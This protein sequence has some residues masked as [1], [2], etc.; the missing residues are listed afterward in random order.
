MS[1]TTPTAKKEEPGSETI[2]TPT[3]QSGEKTASRAARIAQEASAHADEHLHAK[4]HTPSPPGSTRTRPA[5]THARPPRPHVPHAPHPLYAPHTPHAPHAPHA[6]RTRPARTLRMHGCTLPR[7]HGRTR[8]R[9]ARQPRSH[10]RMYGR[11]ATSTTNTAIGHGDC[12][13]MRVHTAQE[14]R[15]APQRRG[16]TQDSRGTLESAR[17]S[18]RACRAHMHECSSRRTRSCR[19]RKRLKRRSLSDAHRCRQHGLWD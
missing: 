12:A 8:A 6:P 18:A 7:T 3:G 19:A 4:S 13:R 9:K 10:E 14:A 15:C 5:R 2:D 17:A 16:K 11:T 1:A